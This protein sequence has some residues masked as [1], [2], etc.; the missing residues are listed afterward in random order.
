[1]KLA[2]QTQ[3]KQY[4]DQSHLVCIEHGFV[5]N[6]INTSIKKTFEFESAMWHESIIHVE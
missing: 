5:L 3:T 1:M 2:Y 6:K 4:D